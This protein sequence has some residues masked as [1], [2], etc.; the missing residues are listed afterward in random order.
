MDIE[1]L[2]KDSQNFAKEA[3]KYEDEGNL[4]KAK[5][6][7]EKAIKTLD[8][9]INMDKNKYNIEVYNKKKLEYNEKIKDLEKKKM[10]V[11]EGGDKDGKGDKDDP[12]AK[13]K[14]QLSGC[15]VSEA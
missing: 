11:P 15:L 3:K 6:F 1:E 14:E 8:S 9:L 10:P 2:R 5:R 12:D 4:D 13:L 7:F